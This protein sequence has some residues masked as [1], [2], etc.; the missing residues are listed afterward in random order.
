MVKNEL[1]KRCDWLIGYVAKLLQS[2]I[3]KAFSK[4]MNALVSLHDEAKMTLKEAVKKDT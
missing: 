2:E 1:C 4:V 3:S